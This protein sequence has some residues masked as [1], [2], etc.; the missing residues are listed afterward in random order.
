MLCNLKGA[1]EDSGEPC[2]CEQGAP[3][4]HRPQRKAQ[5]LFDGCQ[6]SQSAITPQEH[7]TFPWCLKAQEKTPDKGPLLPQYRTTMLNLKILKC[8]LTCLGH[9]K[10]CHPRASLCVLTAEMVR[11]T[12]RSPGSPSQA[13]G[14]TSLHGRRALS[15]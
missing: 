10:S 3:R 13:Q 9:T 11:Q 12:Q 4:M 5:R 2:R 15:H 7:Q 1:A 8:W 6:T 14:H